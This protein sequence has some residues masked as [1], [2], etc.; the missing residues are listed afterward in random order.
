M[1]ITFGTLLFTL[2]A[3]MLLVSP[4]EAAPTCAQ[5]SKIC[6]RIGGNPGCLDKAR[7]AKCKRTCVWTGTD[8]KQH[9]SEGDC[10]QK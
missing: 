9:P 4:T 7:I 6:Y 8:G 1:K 10:R 3:C 2:F 5:Q